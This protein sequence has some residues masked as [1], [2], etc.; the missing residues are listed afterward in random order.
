MII[1]LVLLYLLIGLLVLRRLTKGKDEKYPITG[2]IIVILIWPIAVYWFIDELVK[3]L[4]GE[5]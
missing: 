2:V 5:L 1:L 3:Y 4:K